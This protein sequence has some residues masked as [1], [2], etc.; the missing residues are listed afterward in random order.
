M[1]IRHYRKPLPYPIHYAGQPQGDPLTIRE[2]PFE[3]VFVI[4][5]DPLLEFT[6]KDLVFMRDLKIDPFTEIE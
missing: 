6:H 1:S 5:E 2:C 4:Y 3:E